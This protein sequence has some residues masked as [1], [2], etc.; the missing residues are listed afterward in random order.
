MTSSPTCPTGGTTG[1][2]VDLHVGELDAELAGLACGGDARCLLVPAADLPAG[3]WD[4][5]RD[6]TRSAC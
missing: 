5:L 4:R 2:I 3:L 6:R 1:R